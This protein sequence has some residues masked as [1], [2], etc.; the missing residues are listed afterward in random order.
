[1]KGR[2]MKL[3]RRQIQSIS[4]SLSSQ[5][6]QLF[7]HLDYILQDLVELG[8]IPEDIGVLYQKHRSSLN[9]RGLDL[10]CGKGS[11]SL[12]LSKNFDVEMVGIDLMSPFIDVAKTR[13]IEHNLQ[14]KVRFKVEDMNDAIT[15]YKNFD[16]VVYAACG[17]IL[18]NPIEA[19]KKVK[20]CIKPHGLVLIDDAFAF[21]PLDGYLTQSMW[22]NAISQSGFKL[23]DYIIISKETQENLKQKQLSTIFQ[24]V[25]ELKALYPEY[26]Y[27]FE[28]YY[29]AQVE[30][31]DI[32]MNHV[33]GV[34]LCLRSI[35]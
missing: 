29:R 3:T 12:Y 8:A 10:G 31:W 5:S 13:S 32:L 15:H 25:H 24:R 34:T 35:D 20:Q 26:R 19:L 23:I 6:S 27:L 14:H 4:K 9:E 16:F 17:D 7:P 1:M 11:V 2:H 30:E 21:E 28:N 33:Y 22:E 18:G